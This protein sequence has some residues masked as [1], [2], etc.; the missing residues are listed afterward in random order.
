MVSVIP[1]HWVFGGC[2]IGFRMCRCPETVIGEL[3]PMYRRHHRPMDSRW[4]IWPNRIDGS[5]PWLADQRAFTFLEIWRY[6]MTPFE[7]TAQP[8]P[9][10]SPTRRR[11]LRTLAAAGAT[12]SFL[13][14]SRAYADP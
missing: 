5:H 2:V 11:F 10:L 1:K 4:G 3:I 12:C 7:A 8:D 14:T 13:F 9:S 6:A